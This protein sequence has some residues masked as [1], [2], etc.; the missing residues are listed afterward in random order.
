MPVHHTTGSQ[1]VV[2]SSDAMLYDY[3]TATV[4][5]YYGMN[6][7]KD[8]GHFSSPAN[9]NGSHLKIGEALLSLIFNGKSQK[10]EPI[11]ST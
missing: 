4:L 11:Y 5:L 6:L 7:R 9:A 2:H 1:Q 8:Q 3:V 10:T